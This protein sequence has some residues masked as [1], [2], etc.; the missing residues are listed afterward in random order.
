MTVKLQQEDIDVRKVNSNDID[1]ID[2]INM[3]AFNGSS[4]KELVR[5]LRVGKTYVKDLSLVADIDVNLASAILFKKSSNQFEL[6]SDS[7]R[8]QIGYIMLTE[9]SIQNDEG[10]LYNEGILA[11]APVSVVPAFQKMGVGKKMI[12]TSIKK[13]KQLGYSLIIVLGHKEYYSKFGFET[14]KKYDITSPF[15]VPDENFMILKLN[16]FSNEIRGLVVYPDEFYIV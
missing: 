13:A 1:A 4:E 14:S 2:N 7:M 8:K 12:E 6:V 3:I 5:K 11:L 15:N 16:D 9:V 10:K